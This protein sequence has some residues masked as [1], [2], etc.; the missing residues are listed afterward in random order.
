VLPR[1]HLR[2]EV[3]EA[4]W[5][6]AALLWRARTSKGDLTADTLVLA[7]GPLSEPSVPAIPGLDRFAG[8]VFHSATW[9]HDHDLTGERVAV[10]GTGAS[11]IQFVP[12]VQRAA[13][14]MT[15][16]QRTA[17]W[18][19]PRRDYAIGDTKRRVYRRWPAAQRAVRAASY[20]VRESWVLGFQHPRVMRLAEQGA[21]AFLKHQVRD[22]EL[23]RKLTPH[24]RL[25]CKRVLL[26]NDYYP[27]L[28]QPNAE[29]VTDRLTEVR[30]DGI[31]TTAADGATRVHAVDTIIFGTGFHVT[32][33]PAAERVYGAAGRSLAERWR[34]D[35]MAAHR[36]ITVAGYPNMFFLL[37][38]NT[39]LGHTSVVLVAEKQ[40]EYLLD[41]LRQLDARGGG[42]IEPREDVQRAYNARV[43]QRL[44]GTVWN[45]GG[46]KSWYLDDRGVNTTLWPGFVTS[47]RR[48]VASC[49]LGDYVVH[50]PARR[51]D[52]VPA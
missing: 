13:A 7:T 44:Q 25:G 22:A 38:P 16:F 8:T 42:A 9:R 27:A 21:L 28:T 11:A 24:Y 18:V 43:Q 33:P 23:R 10:I 48:Q 50:E 5:D 36:G 31:V 17:P 41:A 40:V 29:V 2:T 30:P 6:A 12:H 39:G 1:I 32:D 15:L 4:R 51:T 26:S 20:A 49:D 52:S 47:L 46:C 35:G 45:A 19:L 34:S 37:G 3:L 14:H